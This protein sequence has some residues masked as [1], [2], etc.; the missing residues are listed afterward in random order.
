[1]RY[2]TKKLEYLFK[3]LKNGDFLGIYHIPWYYLFARF[4]FL[5]TGNRLCHVGSVFD[6]KRYNNYVSF[7]LGEQTLTEGKIISEYVIVK[8]DDNKYSIDSRFRDKFVNLFLLSNKNILLDSDNLK[9]YEYWKDKEEY[10]ITELPFNMNWF[11]NLF[12]NTKKLYDNN[13]SSACRAAMLKIGIKDSSKD[14]PVPNP[15]EFANFDYIS[16]I[17]K[18][19]K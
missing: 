3:N 16:E 11:Y 8:T 2:K 4:I 6:V 17:I 7:K 18:I 12:G 13:C 10:S 15:T 19:T 14:D 9:I 1:M 5:V